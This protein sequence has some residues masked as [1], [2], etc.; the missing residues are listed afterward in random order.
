MS[1]N[2]NLKQVVGHSLGG[3]VAVKLQVMLIRL[4]IKQI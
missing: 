4:A 2:P 1:R 3:S